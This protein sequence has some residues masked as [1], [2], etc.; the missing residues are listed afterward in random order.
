MRDNYD[1]SDAMKNRYMTRMGNTKFETRAIILAATLLCELD[2]AEDPRLVAGH[3]AVRPLTFL[4]SVRIL[5]Q[6]GIKRL[7]DT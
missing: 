3:K 5:E 1:F 7:T 6:Y 4:E 2:R